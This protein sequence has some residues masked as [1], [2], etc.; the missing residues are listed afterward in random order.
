M[1]PLARRLLLIVIA[2]SVL[3]RVGSAVYQGPAITAMPG[4][5]DQVSYHELALRVLDGHGFSFGTGWW[6]ATRANEPTAHWS[7]LYVL[8]LAAVYSVF[9]PEPLAARLIQALLAGALQP[10]L[11]WRIG[12][13]L[14]GMRVGL[15]SAGLTAVYAYFVFYG[16]ALVTEAFFFVAFLWVLD[17]ATALSARPGAAR[18]LWRWT[19]LGLAMGVSML[20]RQAFMLVIPAIFAWLAWELAVRRREG[21]APRLG[22]MSAT[23][24]TC[25]AAVVLLACIL[26]WTARNYRAFGE[27]VL[28]NT[29]AGF[30]FYWANHPVHGT[31]FIPILGTGP[32]NYGSILPSGL[33][34]LNEA[35]L[36]RALL[37]EGVAF[38][39]ADPARY[40]RLSLSRAREYFKFWPSG[41]S[42]RASNLARLLSYGVVAPFL[43]A[44]AILAL[45]RWRQGGPGGSSGALFLLLV[46]AVYS[47]AHLLTWTLVRYRL[48][49]DAVTMPLAAYA[50]V[51]L[52][53]RQSRRLRVPEA[54]G[55][56]RKMMPATHDVSRG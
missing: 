28:L 17:R 46:A 2:V 53:E 50:M 18:N 23:G 30:V 25:I 15:V 33:E 36:D 31:D 42:G 3:A 34:A 35:Q 4:V 10:W 26:P 27:F 32:V 5:A 8:F 22:L 6:P 14:F 9:G 55:R 52:F 21:G 13:R 24:R 7:F 39:A 56:R 45:V 47:M 20:L 51:A 37:R 40:A 49:V 41:N 16:G 29:N 12:Y 54:G 1:T 11:A 38:V 48:P 43:L 19:V 44:G